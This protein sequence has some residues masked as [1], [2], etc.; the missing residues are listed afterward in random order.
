MFKNIFWVWFAWAAAALAGALWL[1]LQYSWLFKLLAEWQLQY[2][3]WYLP[4]MTVTALVLLFLLPLVAMVGLV[5]GMRKRGKS[6]ETDRSPLQI[7][8]LFRT[9]LTFA[10]VAM[11]VGAVVPLILALSLPNGTEPR[12]VVLFGD[13]SPATAS[14]PV[15]LSGGAVDK[16]VLLHH[17]G[18]LIGYRDTPYAM[19]VDRRDSVGSV[20]VEMVGK[21]REFRLPSRDGILIRDGLPGPIEVLYRA[22][23]VSVE[24]PNFVLFNSVLS[25][26]LPYYCTAAELAGFALLA[27][28]AAGLQGRRVRK[29]RGKLLEVAT[30]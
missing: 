2:L 1:G 22:Q 7:A 9:V 25:Y 8:T 26:R 16:R 13:I 28:I 11:A 30:P 24:T 19:L 18:Y 29:V 15:T 3:G 6:L 17:Q 14:G 20:F 5:R 21:D 23:G 12:R 10:A 27:G 4:A